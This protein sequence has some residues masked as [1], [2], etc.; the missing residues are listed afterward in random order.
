MSK[1]FS[2]LSKSQKDNSVFSFLNEDINYYI[3]DTGKVS[4]RMELISNQLATDELENITDVESFYKQIIKY[5]EIGTEGFIFNDFKINSLDEFINAINDI[6]EKVN[7]ENSSFIDSLIN[8]KMT[9]INKDSKVKDLYLGQKPIFT[10]T[11][12]PININ[13]F[14]S[15]SK[16][17]F[18]VDKLTSTLFLEDKYLNFFSRI[19]KETYTTKNKKIYFI[20]NKDKEPV[21]FDNENNSIHENALKNLIL[22]LFIDGDQ[23]EKI[24]NILNFKKISLNGEM[25]RAEDKILEEKAKKTINKLKISNLETLV[26]DSRNKA[27]AI[28]TYIMKVINNIKP[29]LFLG[30]IEIKYHPKKVTFKKQKKK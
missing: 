12:T 20:K 25:K 30:K 3:D 13:K 22:S 15:N 18:I 5:H 21:I 16:T 4:L 19:I 9:T 23:I 2:Y 29:K 8:K 24:R 10:V 6:N 1:F 27:E 7:N 11:S 28:E 26:E 14:L 17:F